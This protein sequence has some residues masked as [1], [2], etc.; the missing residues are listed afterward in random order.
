VNRRNAKACGAAPDALP[1]SGDL[2]RDA[3]QIAAIIWF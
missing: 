2:P 3:A 1:G